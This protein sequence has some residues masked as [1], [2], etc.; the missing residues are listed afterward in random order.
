[1]EATPLLAAE[2]KKRQQEHGGTAPGKAKNTSLTN[3]TSVSGRVKDIVA[4]QFD[5]NQ[6]L[7]QRNWLVRA[8][9]LAGTAWFKSWYSK[10]V[11]QHCEAT[12]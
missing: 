9:A 6:G 8:K 4:K 12:L 2:A 5:V 7:L 11:K 10:A 3:E 1:L